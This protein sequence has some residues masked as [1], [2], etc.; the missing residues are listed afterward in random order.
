[1]KYTYSWVLDA[2][3]VE[4]LLRD[5]AQDAEVEVDLAGA[6]ASLLVHL[7]CTTLA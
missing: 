1:M 4:H 2:A 5:W 7:F 6:V 3:L